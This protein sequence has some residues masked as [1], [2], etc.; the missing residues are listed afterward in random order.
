MPFGLFFELR[1]RNGWGC[2]VFSEVC[3]F[4]S[5][6]RDV[7][8]DLAVHALHVHELPGII[9]DVGDIAPSFDAAQSRQRGQSSSL[10]RAKSD[11]RSKTLPAPLPPTTNSSAAS[12]LGVA[13]TK[14]GTG[15]LPGLGFARAGRSCTSGGTDGPI[16]STSALCA[17]N[18]VAPRGR[19][20]SGTA[21][22][23]STDQTVC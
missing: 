22:A 1:G 20:W 9:D 14:R 10:P 23:N 18:L 2:R 16:T 5:A 7:V 4:N 19:V 21:D 11:C 12:D 3:A 6:V 15:T 17:A 8:V 13:A